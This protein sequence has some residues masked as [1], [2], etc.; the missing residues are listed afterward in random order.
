MSQINEHVG[1]RIRKYRKSR[2]LTLQ[3]LADQIHKSRA[4][5]SKYET[6]EVSLD[7]ETL[8]EIADVLQV[9]PGQL[10]DYHPPIPKPSQ[11]M[12]CVPG[13]RGMSPFFQARRLYF[14][15]YDGR[16][17]R[18]K[19]GI[20]DIQED[21][22]SPGNFHAA[23]SISAVTSAGRSSEVYYTGTVLYSDMLIRFSFVN[24]CNALEEDLL[25]IFNPLEIRDSTEGLLCG[26]S[27][28]DLM[29]CAFKCLVTLTPKEYTEA[30]KKQLLISKSELQRWQKMN[31]LIVNN[32]G[33]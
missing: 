4:S 7:I 33:L 9:S 18:L 23:L 5:V 24:Q 30:F 11:V 17:Q 32:R 10:M 14:Y 8:F 22:D 27:S 6:G 20:I 13:R 31:M 16:Y 3:Q 1:T 25:Y 15:F 19:D 28:A 26:I 12:S 29:P 2:G 21:A